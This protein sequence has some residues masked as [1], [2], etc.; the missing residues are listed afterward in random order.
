MSKENT[1]IEKRIHAQY[2][3]LPHIEN[4][5]IDKIVQHIDRP[6][7]RTRNN[8]IVFREFAVA[9]C[10]LLAVC[11]GLFA[12]QSQTYSAHNESTENAVFTEIEKVLFT[13]NISELG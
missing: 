6:A 7:P 2:G 1:D 8:I 12:G 9:A 5:M 10:L 13:H 4:N 11:G 3:T